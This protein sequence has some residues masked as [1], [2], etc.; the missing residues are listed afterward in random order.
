M[1]KEKKKIGENHKL[2]ILEEAK[3]T[4]D[5]G[6]ENR[7]NLELKTTYFLTLNLAII[8]ILLIDIGKKLFLDL[9]K[10]YLIFLGCMLFAN[11]VLH[12][13]NFLPFHYYNN[14]ES[15]SLRS[16]DKY[17]SGKFILNL[18]QSYENINRKNRENNKKK[19]KILVGIYFLTI[20][21]ISYILTCGLIQLKW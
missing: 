9:D 18:I 21:I 19:A 5:L 6:E 12:L 13:L 16:E 15:K 1:S 3:K 8:S 11:L 20:I 4:F 2:L 7:K 14:P 10:V 17:N